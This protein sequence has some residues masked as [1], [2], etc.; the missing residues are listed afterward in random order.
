MLTRGTGVSGVSS[1]E[2]WFNADVMVGTAILKVVDV[3]APPLLSLRCRPGYAAPTGRESHVA[4]LAAGDDCSE[5]HDKDRGDIDE[6]EVH[7]DNA[8]VGQD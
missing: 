4:L 5:L 2:V 6:V 8:A 3:D 7:H 1:S